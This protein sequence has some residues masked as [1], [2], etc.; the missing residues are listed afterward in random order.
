[1]EISSILLILFYL[2]IPAIILYACKK[3]SLAKKLGSIVIAYGIGIL[4]GLSG[5][6]PENSYEIQ[7]LVSSASIP[8]AIPLLLF[9]SKIKEWSN[10]AGSSFKSLLVG[11]ISVT[12]I[13][14]IG[15]FLFKPENGDE[16]WKVGALLIGVYTGGTPNLASIKEMLDVS[17]EVYLVV[18][19]YDMVFST[20]YFLFLITIGKRFFLLFL[21]AFKESSKTNKI[22]SED[23]DVFD[24]IFNKKSIWP[25]TKVFGLAIL[26]LGISAGFASLMPKEFFMITVILS[27]SSLALIASTIKGVNRIEVSFDFGMY[28]ILV[29]SVTVASM[30]NLEELVAASLDLIYYPAFVIFGSLLLQ[31]LFSKFTKTDAD[32]MMITS[33]ALI[34]SPPFVPVV[35][36]AINN[37][38]LLVPGITIGLIGYAAGN[39]LGFIVGEI[40]QM[41]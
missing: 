3:S 7:D 6:L 41:L 24:K 20:L 15:Y 9:P 39:Y 30:V 10:L 16:F 23:G 28:F 1:M 8:I 40:L 37:R 36:T 21:P 22:V 34:C 13:V 35:S 29:F 31:T 12:I 33:T 4:L 19:S 11:M 27:L 2:F 14:F 5:F 26:I 25:L 18:H 32:T 38:N 17:N